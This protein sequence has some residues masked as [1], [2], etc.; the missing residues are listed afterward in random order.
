MKPCYVCETT[1]EGRSK[2]C[3]RCRTLRDSRHDG[4]LKPDD[5]RAA[6]DKAGNCFRCRYSGVCLDEKNRKSP[7]FRSVDHWVPGEKKVVLCGWLFNFMKSSLTGPEFVTVVPH[8]DDVLQGLV[9]F[10]KEII[11]FTHW[12]WTAATSVPKYRPDPAL[13]L[14][15]VQYCDICGST[16]LRYSLY[17][18]RCNRL[19]QRHGRV[20]SQRNAFK[21]SYNKEL[22]AFLCYYTK[23]PLEITGRYGPW[24]LSLD[25]RTPGDE[26]SQ[27]VAALWVNR[28]KTYLSELQFRAVI[29]SLANHIRTGAPYD[30]SVVD[31]M[32]YARTVR[33]LG[34]GNPMV[35]R[36]L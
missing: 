2:L 28:L 24:H 12:N 8:L 34:G 30:R 22:D 18:A 11:K 23:I 29:R 16:P 17:C 6:F 4:A 31:S 35:V 13:R 36:R 33:K 5:M 15:D 19:V 7:Y 32:K 20:G 21:A 26:S 9:P 25:H 1:F 10:N 27:V 3:L 14:V